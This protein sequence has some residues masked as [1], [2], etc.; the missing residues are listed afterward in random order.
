M[1]RAVLFL[2][3]NKKILEINVG[4]LLI[5][6][7]DTQIFFSLKLIII[8]TTIHFIFSSL[9]I[10]GF[11]KASFQNSHQR[12]RR[13]EWRQGVFVRKKF[14]QTT[15]HIK[16]CNY[17]SYEK[18]HQT[19]KRIADH[20]GYIDISRLPRWNSSKNTAATIWTE[21]IL[22]CPPRKPGGHLSLIFL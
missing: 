4:K 2:I 19:T 9:H 7:N 15:Q 20:P 18:F 8:S 13:P 16:H 22:K 11:A 5:F 14:L 3:L 12:Q 10:D 21:G 6:T 1:H 17:Q